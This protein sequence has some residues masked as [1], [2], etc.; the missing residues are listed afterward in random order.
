[1]SMRLRYGSFLMPAAAVLLV[2]H[3]VPVAMVLGISFTEPHAGLQNYRALLTSGAAQNALATTF[4]IAV[5]TTLITVALG[6]VYALIAWKSRPAI[7]RLMINTVALT[8]WLSVLI[9]TVAWVAI[10]RDNGILNGLL[11]AI[12]LIA[13]PLPL[14]RNQTGVLIG[15]VHYMLPL[16]VLPVYNSLRAVPVQ[17]LQAARSMS[18]SGAYILRTVVLPQ[19]TPGIVAACALVFMLSLGFFVT[20]AI[21]GGG[22]VVMVAE[23]IRLQIEETVRWGLASMMATTLLVAVCVSM[24][25]AARAVGLKR[26]FQGH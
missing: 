10:L 15:M 21:L 19:C 8:F 25:L 2:F 11:Q 22:K 14:L 13:T 26:I 18:A 1:V 20:P 4:R 24:G 16:A 5:S 9:R 3:L 7:G 23:Y 12:G 6:T 17:Q